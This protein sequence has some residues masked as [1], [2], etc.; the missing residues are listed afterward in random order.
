MAVRWSR[1]ELTLN[2]GDRLP[3]ATHV[4]L[5]DGT[6]GEA[7]LTWESLDE[8]VASVT[9][10]GVVSAN[11]PG[12]TELIATLDGWLA[13][14]LRIAVRRGVD[15]E[16][17]LLS[18]RFDSLDTSRWQLLGEPPPAT[19][20]IDG[21][22]ALLLG[23]DGRF[24]DGVILRDGYLMPRGGTLEADVKVM[25]TDRAD[26]QG[27]Q[28]CLLETEEPASEPEDLRDSSGW[29]VLQSACFNYPAAELAD[30]E[31]TEA[32]F[33]A[34]GVPRGPLPLDDVFPTDDWVSVAMQVRPDGH[35]SLL[36]NRE[37]RLAFDA[38][39]RLGE[40][41]R[42]RVRISGDAVDTEVA[43]RNV[44]LWGEVRYP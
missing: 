28:L 16:E 14:T 17:R 21:E 22:P 23:G 34:G 9:P 13:D 15:V 32:R 40:G 25:L 42:W 43:V 33:N 5:S 37:L 4:R 19:G 30:R 39:I 11:R 31:D 1:D 8:S 6:L 7:D 38:A 35:A 2:W 29:P 41:T 3:V 20:T 10:D 24:L 26:R 18:E 36:I 44:L 27:I 12:R